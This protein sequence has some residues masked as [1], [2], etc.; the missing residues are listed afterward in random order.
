[1]YCYI[2]YI[3]IITLIGSQR[4]KIYSQLYG[5]FQIKFDPSAVQIKG[6]LES[7]VSK[8]TGLP[9]KVVKL[10]K[11]YAVCN[12]LSSC[13]RYI[14]FVYSPDGYYNRSEAVEDNDILVLRIEGFQPDGYLNKKL[15][16]PTEL[17]NDRG[18]AKFYTILRYLVPL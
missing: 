17:Q 4:V 9:L 1:M 15:Y 16:V 7:K 10:Y 11:R 5:T 12:P 13:Y 14:P 2:V 8:Y 6:S 18:C 3:I